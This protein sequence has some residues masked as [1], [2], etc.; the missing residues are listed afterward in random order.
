MMVYYNN[1]A[2]IICK[3]CSRISWC[4]SKMANKKNLRQLCLHFWYYSTLKLL[5]LQWG[6]RWH[7]MFV[8]LEILM[9]YIY[10]WDKSLLP[11]S[12]LKTILFKVWFFFKDVTANIECSIFYLP[13]GYSSM[14]ARKK[15]EQFVSM[16]V[17]DI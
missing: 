15:S 2:D 4:I 1:K 9:I 11:S 8:F 7:L 6:Y 14:Y 12:M 13:L 16:L 17:L 10:C 3:L 5:V